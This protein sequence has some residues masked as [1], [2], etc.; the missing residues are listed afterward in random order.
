[1]QNGSRRK[2]LCG[3]FFNSLRGET[4]RVKSTKTGNHQMKNVPV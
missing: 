2:K 1:M 3:P 4:K